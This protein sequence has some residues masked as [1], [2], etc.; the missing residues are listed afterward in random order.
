MF[1][2]L[3][4]AFGFVKELLSAIF[5]PVQFLADHLNPLNDEF[6]FKGMFENIG[7]SATGIGNIL[8]YINP[9]SDNFFLKGFLS[10]FGNL[11]Y[12][13]NPFSENFFLKGFLS[14][15]GNLLD[16]L[17]PFSENF[18]VYKLIELLKEALSFLFVPS[19]DSINSLVDSVKSHFAF[20]DT[21]SNT[22][23]SIKDMFSGTDTL[24]V[25]K[26]S[27]PQ[28]SWYNGEVTVLD[29]NW[30]STYKSYGDVI[31]SAF[32][33]AFFLWRMFIKLPSIISGTGGAI[34]DLPT[35]VKDI[36]N[37]IRRK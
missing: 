16:W 36:Q 5:T 22:A 23:N 31:I 29:L 12:S 14:S 34:E 30:Y 21:I 1:K 35:Q 2:G 26:V 7:N 15:F 25:I 37:V 20:I 10:S 4:D 3:K 32:I 6:I 9:F 18:F 27:L 28:N 11:L 33:Y 8:S 24:P 17:N 19:E 13:L